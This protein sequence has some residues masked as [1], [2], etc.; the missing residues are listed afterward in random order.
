VE[1]RSPK[2]QVSA[3]RLAQFSRDG[4]HTFH[5]KVVWRLSQENGPGQNA[6]RQKGNDVHG[7]DF[8]QACIRLEAEKEWD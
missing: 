3:S 4:R 8:K 6:C 2:I 7:R 1:R 5:D